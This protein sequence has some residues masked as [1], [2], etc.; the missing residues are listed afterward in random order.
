MFRIALLTL[1]YDRGK[2][3][4][5]LAGVAFAA[6]LALAQIGLYFGF[7]ETSSSLIRHAGGDVWVMAKGT[8]VLDNGERMSAGT[9]DLLAAHPCVK[10]VRAVIIA[11]MPLRKPDGSL[12]AV[13]II[14][15]DPG[16]GPAM[17]WNLRRGLPQDLHGPARVSVDDLDFAKL[18]IDGEAIGTS[19][20]VGSEQVYVAAVTEGIRSFTLSPYLFAENETARRVANMSDGQATYWVVDLERPSCAT[21]VIE[22]VARHPDLDAYTTDEFRKMTEHYWVSGSGAGTALGFSAILG[23][24]VGVVIVGQTLYAVTKEHLRELATLKAIGAH[25][26][27]IV[28]FVAWQA[29]FLAVV[30]GGLG[31]V[32]AFSV[33]AL[34]AR[35]G[36]FIV[37]DRLVLTVGCGAVLTMCAV[38]SLGSIRAVL[39]LEAA[40]VF[41]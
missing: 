6:T 32:M 25:P 7:L 23:L 31:V 30:G 16:L 38:A 1:A 12:D 11:F 19:L 24:V 40:E 35:H 9:R 15:Y 33:Q 39:E 14:G 2:L 41:Q 5:S 4:A 29:A 26:N 28:R 18:A 37:L 17:P 34:A 3:V 21:D 8:R 22:S 27:E 20:R 13:Q 10:T 36:L